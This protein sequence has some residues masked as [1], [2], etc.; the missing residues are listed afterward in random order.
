[1]KLLTEQQVT[2]Y[3][4]EGATHPVRVLSA[5]RA[6]GYLARLE[7]GEAEIPDFGKV[8][9]TKSHLALK[10]MDEIVNDAAVLDAVEDLLGPDLLLYTLTVWIKNACDSSFVSWHPDSAY[11]PLD[12]EVQVTAW[13]ALTDSIEENGSVK[14]LPGTHKLGPLEHGERMA[15]GN[16]LAKG[17]TV[18]AALDTSRVKSIALQPGEMSLHHT[19]LVHYS[20]ANNSSRRRIGLGISYIPTSVRCTSAARLTGMLVRGGDR[21][22]HFEHEPRV[23]FDFDPRVEEFRKDAI[24][25][26]N[27]AREEQ[28]EVKRRRFAG[29]S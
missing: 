15:Q 12:P 25:R 7:Q 21:Y 24:V 6:A 3:Q 22:D 11:F 2:Q 29:A 18:V 1:M 5:S 8:L 17:Q 27:Q 19:G 23:R 14:Y 13:I 9:R 28:V 26:Y 16:M 20:E 10:W 4:E